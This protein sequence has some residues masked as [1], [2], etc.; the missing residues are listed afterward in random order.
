MMAPH[1][2][3]ESAT[4]NTGHH[5]TET[6]STTWPCSGPGAR[7]K[8][9]I[10]LPSAPPRT[11]PRPRAHSGERSVRPIR[12]TAMTTH[13]ATMV[14]SHVIPVA[15]ENAAPGLRT[16]RRVTTSPMISTGLPG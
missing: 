14:R 4:L 10:K 5:P 7:K 13:T 1:T 11:S 16:N 3:D 12:M 8:R 9:S 6:K 15:I 2:I